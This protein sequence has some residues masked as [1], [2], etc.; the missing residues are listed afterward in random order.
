QALLRGRSPGKRSAAANSISPR[1]GCQGFYRNAICLRPYAPRVGVDVEALLAQESDQRHARG[2]RQ[3]DSETG[4][5]GDGSHDRD[6]RGVRFL[7]NFEPC[8][9]RN[10]QDGGRER[11]R[12]SEKGASH[13][14]VG[15]IMPTDILPD[16][17]HLPVLAKESRGVEAAGLGEDGLSIAKPRRKLIKGLG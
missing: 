14:L 11:Q 9:A 6:A 7:N 17:T 2:L 1:A 4:R 13:Q 12:R 5:S 8:A 15:G 10:H 16:L 3:L